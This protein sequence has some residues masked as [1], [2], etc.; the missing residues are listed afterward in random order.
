MM[1]MCQRIPE[2]TDFSKLATLI[3]LMGDLLETLP[4]F[5]MN[6]TLTK[7]A[8]SGK[9]NSH[10]EMT[11][12]GNA[13]NNYCRSYIYE[14]YRAI[15]IPEAE[16]AMAHVA[17]LDAGVYPDK[18]FLKAEENRIRDRF[19]TLPLSEFAPAPTPFPRPMITRY[20][21][22]MKPNAANASALMPATQKLSMRLFKNI[23]SIENIVGKANLLMA[24][25]GEP[26]MESIF[27][28]AILNRHCFS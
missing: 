4:E 12:K 6:H 15:Y 17:A 2:K 11:L 24:F 20:R 21:G 23:K 14:L 1:K 19:Y 28:F 26:V 27:S 7:T 10:A 8:Q 3:T 25:F 13:E 16:C 18:D 22:E 9:L 5:S